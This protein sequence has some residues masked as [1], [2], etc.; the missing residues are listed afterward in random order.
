LAPFDPK[1]KLKKLKTW[2][3]IPSKADFEETYLDYEA[4]N[5]SQQGDE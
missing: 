1:K 2:D 3:Q 4:E 5:L